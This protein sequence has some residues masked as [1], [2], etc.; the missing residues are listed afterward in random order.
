MFCLVDINAKIITIA[1]TSN[2][3]WIA[4]KETSR[5]GQNDYQNENIQV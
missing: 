4:Q 5:K 1:Y 2:T 3:K